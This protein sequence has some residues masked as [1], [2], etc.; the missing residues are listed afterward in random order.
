MALLI[1]DEAT[2][3]NRASF[4]EMDR[5]LRHIMSAVHADAYHWPFGG[6]CILFGGDWR[7]TLPVI[8]RGSKANT[9]RSCLKSSLLWQHIVKIEL[10]IQMRQC[11]PGLECW[12]SFLDDVGKGNFNDTDSAPCELPHMYFPT[13]VYRLNDLIE[14]VFPSGAIESN[15]AILCLTNDAVLKVNRMILE[16]MHTSTEITLISEDCVLE[17]TAAH[18]IST[19]YLNSLSPPGLPLHRLQLKVG[20]I[21]MLLRNLH[22][23]TGLCNGTLMRVLCISNNCLSVKLLNGSHVGSVVPIP[24]IS[25]TSDEYADA[26]IF[27]RHQFPVTLAFAMTV[28]KSQGQTFD[29]VGLYFPTTPFSH[30]QLYVALTR[31]RYPS[32]MRMMSTEESNGNVT[33]NVVFK[34]IF[35]MD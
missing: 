15:R 21:V 4:E 2:M 1:V 18:H 31:T 8:K 12:R 29:R 7:Q 25:L 26:F 24:R 27:K 5:S 33:R 17:G 34:A 16:T 14:F 30:G 19:E 23:K 6:V 9:L 13:P 28:N 35:D 3:L 11:A 22:P 20:A 10:T 32:D